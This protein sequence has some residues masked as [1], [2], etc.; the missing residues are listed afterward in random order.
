LFVFV[1]VFCLGARIVLVENQTQGL[2]HLDFSIPHLTFKKFF[3]CLLFVCFETGV[4]CVALAVLNGTH[5]VDQAGLEL[6]DIH[7]PLFPKYWEEHHHRWTLKPFLEEE[8]GKY[9]PSIPALRRQR[10]VDLCEFKVSLAYRASP[11]QPQLHRET[12]SQKKKKQIKKIYFRSSHILH[13][14]YCNI[15]L[16]MHPQELILLRQSLTS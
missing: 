5:Y 12:V 6:T 7:L 3:F 16:L 1:F 9:T 4:L 8:V 13:N 2:G 11:R 15:V 14:S 10:Q